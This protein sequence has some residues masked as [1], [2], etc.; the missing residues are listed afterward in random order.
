MRS[1][2]T[3]FSACSAGRQS[4]TDEE[5]M[6]GEKKERFQASIKPEVT[7]RISLE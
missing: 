1:R 5:A 7:Q 2:L 4:V 6:G 3:R